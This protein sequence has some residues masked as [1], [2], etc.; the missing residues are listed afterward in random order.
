VTRT[1]TLAA[2][3]TQITSALFAKPPKVE[4]KGEDIAVD[5]GI[6]IKTTGIRVSG[7]GKRPRTIPGWEASTAKWM[8]GSLCDR[9][10][11]RVP[12]PEDIAVEVVLQSHINDGVARKVCQLLLTDRMDRTIMDLGVDEQAKERDALADAQLELASSNEGQGTGPDRYP[13]WL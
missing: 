1:Q 11:G 7:L 3:L 6:I 10:E 12:V 9:G 4:I 13:R 2:Y 8:D 5:G